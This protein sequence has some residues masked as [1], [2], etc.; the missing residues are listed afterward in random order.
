MRDERILL[1]PNCDHGCVGIDRHRGGPVGELVLRKEM[2][3]KRRYEKDGKIAV[4]IAPE[5]GGGFSTWSDDKVK[6]TLLFH[7]ALVEKV[8]SG[9]TL[10]EEDVERAL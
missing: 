9:E 6:E 2:V 5:F 4:L 7:P 3:M 1:V 8:L 10:E